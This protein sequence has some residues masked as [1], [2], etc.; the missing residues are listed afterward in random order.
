MESKL[1]MDLLCDPLTGGTLVLFGSSII[2][3]L[4]LFPVGKYVI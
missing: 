1:N 3:V 4:F 2:P